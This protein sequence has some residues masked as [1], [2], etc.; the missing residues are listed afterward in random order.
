MGSGQH[1]YALITYQL[2][3]LSTYKSRRNSR[4]R[5]GSGDSYSGN[6]HDRR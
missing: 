6:N 4:K 2:F 3:T 5:V 1:G